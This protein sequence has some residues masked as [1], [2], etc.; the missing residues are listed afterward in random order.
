MKIYCNHKWKGPLHWCDIGCMTLDIILS[1]KLNR[2]RLRNKWWKRCQYCNT[3]I[4]FEFPENMERENP[5]I[6]IG[7]TK[8]GGA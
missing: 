3:I 8:D 4:Y 5:K 6:I 2:K 1:S 7:K